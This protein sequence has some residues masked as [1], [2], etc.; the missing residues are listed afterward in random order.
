MALTVA[1]FDIMHGVSTCSQQSLRTST[2]ICH[3]GFVVIIM[4]A[5]PHIVRCD[6]VIRRD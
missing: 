1:I 6:R 4:L 2:Q 5:D 3:Q